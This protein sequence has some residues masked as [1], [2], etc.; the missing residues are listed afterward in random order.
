[1]IML[2]RIG[3]VCSCS[4]KSLDPEKMINFAIG[5]PLVSPYELLLFWREHGSAPLL[6][7]L[8]LLSSM[9]I[10]NE[11]CQLFLGRY[12][13]YCPFQTKAIVTGQFDDY[14]KDQDEVEFYDDDEVEDDDDSTALL[15]E[16]TLDID[17]QHREFVDHRHSD[18]MKKCTLKKCLCVKNQHTLEYE[19]DHYYEDEV[20]WQWAVGDYH[21]KLLRI[22]NTP[23]QWIPNLSKISS[24][25]PSYTVE[26]NPED[27]SNEFRGYLVLLPDD[28]GKHMFLDDLFKEWNL[29]NSKGGQ[30]K[31]AEA[32]HKMVERP[33]FVCMEK[34]KLMDT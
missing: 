21:R 26:F 29:N 20:V 27:L 3:D 23:C 34:W 7:Q 6:E 18:F 9:Q 17:N 10:K 8:N 32:I 13:L 15:F 5:H 30:N 19:P 14:K 11:Q 31:Y 12:L 24:I 33:L 2:F 28:D 4:D 1:M 22:N 25:N 16:V